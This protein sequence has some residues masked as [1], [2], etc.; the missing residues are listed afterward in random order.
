M[1]I[2]RDAT[3]SVAHSPTKKVGADDQGQR[4]RC[5]RDRKRGLVDPGWIEAGQ[6]VVDCGISFVDGKTV[7]DV[8]SAAVDARGAAS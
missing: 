6:I 3:V 5:I 1:L 8:D 2:N 4:N 7:G